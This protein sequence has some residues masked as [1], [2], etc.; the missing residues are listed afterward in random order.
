MNVTNALLQKAVLEVIREFMQDGNL[1]N[2]LNVT[3]ALTT[4]AV[5]VFI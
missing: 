5:L 4:K 3:N 2:V 1:I